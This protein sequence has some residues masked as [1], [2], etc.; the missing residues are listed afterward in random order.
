MQKFKFLNL[1]NTNRKPTFFA[2]MGK[3]FA[4]HGFW[5]PDLAITN[6]FIAKWTVNVFHLFKMINIA[7]I[8]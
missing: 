3:N 5:Q 2:C 8:Y 6:N 7:N 4:S 1:M